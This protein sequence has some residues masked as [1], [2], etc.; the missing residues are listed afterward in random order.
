M[1][2]EPIEELPVENVEAPETEENVTPAQ[3]KLYEKLKAYYPDKEFASDTD[4][5]DAAH[6]KLS[7]NDQY[8]EETEK[9]LQNISDAVD[10]DPEYAQLTAYIAKGMGFREAVS[11]L[12][13][14][15]DLEAQDGDPDFDALEAAKQERI[16]K[17]HEHGKRIAEIEANSAE[18]AAKVDQFASDNNLSE[19][20][21]LA[22]LQSVETIV[23][24]IINGKISTDFLAKML[25]AENH[26]KEV[27]EATENARIEG[28]NENIENQKIKAET[29]ASG[30]GIPDIS[31]TS[32]QQEPK[33]VAQKSEID[34]LVDLSARRRKF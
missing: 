1:V 29:V 4:A 2:K 11:R 14:P 18:S 21:T 8:Y 9:L 26:D 3:H 23:A 33:P 12:I 32:V 15:A 31:G 10:A 16:A 19:E 20:E 28:L 24:D 25:T 13:D 6:E 34:D 27:S 5:M 30:D 22:L 17:R 7:E